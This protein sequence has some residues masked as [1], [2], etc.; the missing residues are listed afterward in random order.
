MRGKAKGHALSVTQAKV[1]RANGNVEYHIS[2]PQLKLW[3]IKGR[4][5]V[6]RRINAMKRER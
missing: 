6:R 5:W 1:T 4:L 3:D 2:K